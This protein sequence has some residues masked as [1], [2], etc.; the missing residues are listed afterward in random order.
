MRFHHW[1]GRF[2]TNMH[3]MPKITWNPHCQAGRDI[4][5][6]ECSQVNWE[7]VKS[8]FQN[9]PGMAPWEK[10]DL[11]R[12]FDQWLEDGVKRETARYVNTTEHIHVC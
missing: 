9:A 6:E 3:G 2:G 4:I 7:G 10:T 1:S 11:I 5:C 12:F 8:R